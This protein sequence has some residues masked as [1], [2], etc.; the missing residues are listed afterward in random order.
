MTAD[1]VG[2]S[3]VGRVGPGSIAP[4]GPCRR[5]NTLAGMEEAGQRERHAQVA[6]CAGRMTPGRR[7]RPCATRGF[8][9]RGDQALLRRV[10]RGFERL[11][12][13]I[14]PRCGGGGVEFG[15]FLE[16]GVGG[17]IQIWQGGLARAWLIPVHLR[18][19]GDFHGTQWCAW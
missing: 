1:R 9:L 16:L 11:G 4:P 13:F 19:V 7:G 17:D 3:S 5:K 10:L 14:R 6:R 2:A 15:R 18:L 8:S 12:I